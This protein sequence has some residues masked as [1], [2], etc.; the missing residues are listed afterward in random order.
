MNISSIALSCSAPGVRKPLTDA[1]S[2]CQLLR[3]RDTYAGTS[4]TGKRSSGPK[5]DTA[6][7]HRLA[8]SVFLQKKARQL[9]PGHGVRMSYG[10]RGRTIGQRSAPARVRRPP[11]AE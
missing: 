2:S 1:F 11:R 8:S 4:G 9:F 3:L 10:E 6:R 5:E 7:K